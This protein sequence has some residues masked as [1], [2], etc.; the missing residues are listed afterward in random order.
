MD[1]P[2]RLIIRAEQ[3]RDQ[4]TRAPAHVLPASSFSGFCIP[5]EVPH[6]HPLA[7][8]SEQREYHFENYFPNL[9]TIYVPLL[10]FSSI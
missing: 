10:W 9:M 4:R 8:A 7:P 5:G 2:F 3:F 1:L 6:R